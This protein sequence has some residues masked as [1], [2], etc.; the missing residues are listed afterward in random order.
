MS[1]VDGANKRRVVLQLTSHFLC[2]VN[3]LE[4]HLIA[5]Q[6]MLHYIYIRYH[7]HSTIP[8]KKWAWKLWQSC[9]YCWLVVQ[10]CEFGRKTSFHAWVDTL[11]VQVFLRCRQSNQSRVRRTINTHA[12]HQCAG[13]NMGRSESQVMRAHEHASYHLSCQISDPCRVGICF[14][15]I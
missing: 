10:F 3:K 9:C 2:V 6:D 15:L 14:L 8:M 7:D 4:K 12:E 13:G 5:W 1:S 11:F